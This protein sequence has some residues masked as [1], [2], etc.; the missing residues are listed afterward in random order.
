MPAERSGLASRLSDPPRRYPH[1]PRAFLKK[2]RLGA[3]KAQVALPK[4]LALPHM[5]WQRCIVLQR[6]RRMHGLGCRGKHRGVGED[7]R[8]ESWRSSSRYVEDVCLSQGFSCACRWRKGG[9]VR[10]GVCLVVAGP[11]MP[12][13][14]CPTACAVTR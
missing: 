10:P 6:Q 12:E 5:R 1:F 9:V 2:L 3:D 4:R 11:R 14:V 13:S 7:K 8:E